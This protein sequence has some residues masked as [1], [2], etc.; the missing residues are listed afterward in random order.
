VSKSGGTF[1]LTAG[2]RDPQL[3]CT[4]PGA[5][6]KGTSIA[7]VSL[8]SPARS[9]LQLFFKS[10]PGQEFSEKRSVKMRLVKG[11]NELYFKIPSRTLCDEI[12]LDPGTEI[13]T[14]VL[15]RFELRKSNRSASHEE[16]KKNTNLP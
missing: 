8:H 14:Y 9:V 12:R 3:I 1:V 10:A 16:V 11:D 13:G 4:L 2:N 6:V 7:H 15:K 5:E